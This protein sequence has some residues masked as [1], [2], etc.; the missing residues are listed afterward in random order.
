MV[1][2]P[3]FNLY[4]SDI[5]VSLKSKSTSLTYDGSVKFRKLPLSRVWKK[6]EAYFCFTSVT[7]KVT[8]IF[9]WSLIK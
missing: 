4:L 9:D 8:L 1:K 6:L 7:P 3:V 2:I 5:Y